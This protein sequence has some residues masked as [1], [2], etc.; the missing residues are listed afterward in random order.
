MAAPRPKTGRG[1]MISA[2]AITTAGRRYCAHPFTWRRVLLLVSLSTEA[3]LA[4]KSD[5]IEIKREG[6][7]YRGD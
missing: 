1:L 2:R 3:A 4:A 7:S 5:R 6:L